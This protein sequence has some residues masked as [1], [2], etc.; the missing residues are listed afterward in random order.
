MYLLWTKL[1]SSTI[2]LLVF[3]KT[4]GPITNTWFCKMV[5]EAA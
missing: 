4:S 3:Y 5:Q 2:V 1:L